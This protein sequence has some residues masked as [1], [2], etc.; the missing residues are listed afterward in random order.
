MFNYIKKIRSLILRND[1]EKKFTKNYTNFSTIK[2]NKK[3]TKSK[4]IILF[5]APMDY[6]FVLLTRTIIVE[7]HLN[8]HLI[9]SWPYYIKPLKK[10]FFF[11]SQIFHYTKNIF[12]FSLLRNKWKSIYKQNN[13]NLSEDFSSYN[14]RSVLFSL[15]NI[16]VITNKIKSKRDI[17]KIKFKGIDIGDLIFDTY[18][19]YR[20]VPTVNVNDFFLKYII[21][22][23]LII[24]NNC[25]EFTKKNNIEV[26]Y[27][28]YASYLTHGLLVRILLSKKIKIYSLSSYY[29]ENYITLLNN[30]RLQATKNYKYLYKK[31][32]SEKN[33]ERKINIARASLEKR[34]Y[35]NGDY[36]TKY[37]NIKANYKFSKINNFNYEGV[38]FLHDFYDA[39]RE[40]GLRL[41]SD[42]YEWFEFL[43]YI[44][45]KNDLNF[46]FKFHPNTK[47]ES[48]AFNNYLKKKFHTKFLNSTISN[49]AI[50]KN[51]HFKVG[52]SA[53]GS[54]L[55]E[56]IFFKKIPIY[57]SNNL[58]T[59]LNIHKLPKNKKEYENL[60]VNYNKIK[61]SNNMIKNMLKIYYMTINDQSDLS[62]SIVK[63][64]NLKNGDF[65]NI[66]DINNYAEKIEFKINKLL[67]NK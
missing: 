65:S 12:L 33:Q 47:P 44:T 62:C 14:L 41:F 59:P 36:L 40:I 10:R 50:Y 56:L 11:I 13:I 58:I 25:S 61:I 52:I 21:F 67:T 5:Q 29:G 15:K 32:N 24:F 4:K 53:C 3:K 51:K 42:F 46:A 28:S 1:F 63:K 39:P 35:E 7:R 64:I 48:I 43:N 17:L 54:V 37:L 27:T 57:L 31:F 6:F 22:K 8:D 55:H 16:Q 23:T 49:M 30:K 60:I 38:V 18:I 26:Y 19:R 45:K 34:F 2:S 9:G 20:A 66:S